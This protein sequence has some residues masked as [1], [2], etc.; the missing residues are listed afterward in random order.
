[1]TGLSNVKL[2]QRIQNYQ[3]DKSGAELTF[4][5]RLAREN[6]WDVEFA[7]RA[8]E[9]YK[10]FIY[11]ICVSEGTLTPSEQVDQVWHLH[12]VYTRDYW[13]RFCK[14]TLHRELHHEPTE[15]GMD[16]DAKFNAAYRG[17]LA[18][19]KEQFELNPP[20]DVWPSPETRFR[21]QASSRLVDTETVFIVP[22]KVV[23]VCIASAFAVGA[24][25]MPAPGLTIGMFIVSIIVLAVTFGKIY[26][27]KRSSG[28]G[29]GCGSS[30][31]SGGG[32]CGGD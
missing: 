22:K 9:E 8:T 5:Q 31:C 26:E 14:E 12:M 3:F 21:G 20:E 23:G 32:G 16:E 1:M 7:R 15:G 2:W 25:M 11:L 19:Y 27:D 17:T 4:T 18:H 29:T 10:R 24:L 30:G 6:G 13:Q 28:C